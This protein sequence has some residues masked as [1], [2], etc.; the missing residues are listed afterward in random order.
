MMVKNPKASILEKIYDNILLN[1][2]SQINDLKLFSNFSDISNFL[3]M[4]IKNKILFLYLN[5][6]NINQ[7][8]YDEENFIKIETS[9]DNTNLKYYFFLSLLISE[10]KDTINYIYTYEFINNANNYQKNIDENKI[11]KKLMIAK[12]ILELIDNYNNYNDSD[13]RE[14]ENGSN[15]EEE[16]KALNK[17][18]NENEDIIN[19]NIEYLKQLIPNINKKYITGKKIDTIYIDIIN[20][21]L[22][23]QIF[24]NIDNMIDILNQLES[25]NITKSMIDE[26]LNILNIDNDL[27][28]KYMIKD[29]DDLFNIDKINFYYI[30]FKYLF[31]NSIFIYQLPFINET[32]KMIIKNIK[33]KY[34]Y[35]EPLSFNN[36][37]D[38]IYRKKYIIKKINDLKYYYETTSF[39]T[40]NN[41]SFEKKIKEKANK[42]LED[43]NNIHKIKNEQIPYINPSINSKNDYL[44]EEKEIDLSFMGSNTNSIVESPSEA[45]NISNRNNECSSGEI[46]SDSPFMGNNTNNINSQKEAESVS[47]SSNNSNRNNEYLHVEIV[48]DSSFMGNNTN[49]ISSHKDIESADQSST[50]SGKNKEKEI[51]IDSNN[52]IYYTFMQLKQIIGKHKYTC[53]MIKIINDKLLSFGFDKKI[54]IYTNNE[55]DKKKEYKCSDWINNIEISKIIT[56]KNKMNPIICTKSSLI[57]MNNN[58]HISAKNS[59]FLFTIND[60]KFIL[61]KKDTVFLCKLSFNNI[62]ASTFSPILEGYYREGIVIN[63]K[64]FAITSNRIITGGEDKISFYKINNN[65]I[66]KEIKGYSFILTSTGL[67]LMSFNNNNENN[68]LLCACKKYLKNQKNGILLINLNKINENDKINNNIKF[69][70]TDFFEVHCFYQLS[71]IKEFTITNPESSYKKINYFLVG[72]FDTKRKKGIIKLYKINK[73][74]DEIYEIEK[75]QDIILKNNNEFKGFKGAISCIEL[76]KN[77]IKGNLLITCWDGNVYSFLYPDGKKFYFLNDSK[78]NIS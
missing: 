5:R 59:N 16:E 76:Q 13:N 14:E 62:T 58:F 43:L 8:L 65:K 33:K 61:I 18:K 64:I 53:E 40:N 22:K 67:C 37:N 45:P 38:I 70:N 47:G 30:I 7:I 21:I 17:I 50:I 26:L 49:N 11:Y 6:K 12:I 71:I 34:K 63:K 60:D 73:R 68:L 72:G 77:K 25:I 39:N 9:K 27:I 23:E 78:I 46:D 4:D 20:A 35:E 55:C 29:I 66:F 2:F 48:S 31:K 36:S 42:Y 74:K 24:S 19:K 1:E 51:N 15:N 41:D 44:N 69:Y 32:R 54:Y 52:D 57:Y 3:N 28:K 10:N 75:V 56:D